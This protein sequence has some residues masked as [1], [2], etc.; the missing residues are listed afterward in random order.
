MVG[1]VKLHVTVIVL[2]VG[3]AKTNVRATF[4]PPVA[5]RGVE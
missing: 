3:L 4:K 5:K 1:H 2:L